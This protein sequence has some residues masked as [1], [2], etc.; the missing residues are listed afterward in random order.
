MASIFYHLNLKSQSTLHKHSATK[1]LKIEYTYL[2]YILGLFQEIT[3]KEQEM[4]YK[5]HNNQIKFKILHT[6]LNNKV[7]PNS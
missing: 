2:L 1:T 3:L 5:F 7:F 4:L 6:K